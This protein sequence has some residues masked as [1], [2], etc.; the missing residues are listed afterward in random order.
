MTIGY[1]FMGGRCGW[2]FWWWLLV[3]AQLTSFSIVSDLVLTL[4]LALWSMLV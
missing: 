2:G 3:S 1:W 4:T